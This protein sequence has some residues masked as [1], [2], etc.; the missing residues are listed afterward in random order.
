LIWVLRYFRNAGD[1]EAARPLRGEGG[2]R[3]LA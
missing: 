1:L 3:R 2:R